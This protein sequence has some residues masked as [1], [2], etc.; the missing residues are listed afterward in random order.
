MKRTA[1][2]SIC[3]LTGVAQTFNIEH[4]PKV[5][6]VADPHIS[7]DGRSV[8]IVVSHPNYVDNHFDSKLIRVSLPSGELTHQR[9]TGDTRVPFMRSYK[10]YHALRERGQDVKMILYRVPGHFLADPY[11]IRD[12]DRWWADRFSERLP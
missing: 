10:L 11:R 5:A 12:I 9:R 1:L 3:A 8:M 7:P 2:L 4:Y 6:R